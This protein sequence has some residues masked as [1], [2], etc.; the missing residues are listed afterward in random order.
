MDVYILDRLLWFILITYLD[1]QAMLDTC[2]QKHV[3]LL[4]A[5]H[6]GSIC[7]HNALQILLELK[8]YVVIVNVD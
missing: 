3:L 8:S 7:V 6:F 1:G 2:W 4:N 5:L